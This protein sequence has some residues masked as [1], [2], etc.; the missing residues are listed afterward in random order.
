MTSLFYDPSKVKPINAR[1]ARMCSTGWC[2]FSVWWVWMEGGNRRETCLRIEGSELDS[3]Q[4][5][6]EHV[7]RQHLSTLL[8]HIPLQTMLFIW[9]RWAEGF[10]K[11]ESSASSL[12]CLPSFTV[13]PKGISRSQGVGVYLGHSGLSWSLLTCCSSSTQLWEYMVSSLFVSP[14]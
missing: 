6:N 14:N 8:S 9:Q 13:F 3:K 12:K 4:S 2:R 10:Y 7:N 5:G 1:P 11:Q